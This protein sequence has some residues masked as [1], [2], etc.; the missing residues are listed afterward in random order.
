MTIPAWMLVL[1]ITDGSVIVDM[2][3]LNHVHDPKG[4][5]V[6]S[7]VILWDW[8]SSDGKLH[9]VG[10]TLA[11]GTVERSGGWHR[12]RYWDGRRLIVVRSRAFRE[13]WTH[14]DME[15]K[16][17]RVFWGGVGPNLLHAET[18][19]RETIDGP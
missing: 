4:R 18:V 17:S 12:Y 6:I 13:T 11:G 16:D 15:R 5:C 9:N 14:E 8:E 7:Q 10:W 2:L 19:P 3:E 1:A